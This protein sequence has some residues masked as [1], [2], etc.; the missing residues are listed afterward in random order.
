MLS[1]VEPS[2]IEMNKNKILDTKPNNFFKLCIL[3]C[4]C[5]FTDIFNNFIKVGPTPD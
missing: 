5:I 1:I 2:A 4:G 3:I